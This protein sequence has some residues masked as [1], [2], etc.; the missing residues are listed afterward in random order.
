M[1]DLTTYPGAT[2]LKNYLRRAGAL[3]KSEDFEAAAIADDTDYELAIQA[4]ITELESRTQYHPFLAT[5][6]QE[7]RRFWPSMDRPQQLWD[8][9]SGI[10]PGSVTLAQVVFIAT[11]G[12][13]GN[14]YDI[15]EHRD[16]HFLPAYPA[17][18]KRPFDCLKFI[19]YGVGGWAGGWSWGGISQGSR[20]VLSLTANWGYWTT[21]PAD[22]Y[23]AILMIGAL[24][25]F[26]P[27]RNVGISY[28]D[29]GIMSRITRGDLTVE[30]ASSVQERRAMVDGWQAKSDKVVGLYK[31]PGIW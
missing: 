10:I 5:G 28:G 22:A 29:G 30:F 11:D 25:L 12:T 8:L 1:A 19:R 17:P 2:D 14:A 13:D 6:A 20:G 26:D 23:Q 9:A 27:L 31:R 4:A 3:P 15:V 7:N 21:V 24:N 16:F 18:Q